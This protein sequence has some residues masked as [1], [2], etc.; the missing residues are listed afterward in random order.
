MERKAGAPKDE[1]MNIAILNCEWISRGPAEWE[2]QRDNNKKVKM[3]QT[4]AVYD[5]LVYLLIF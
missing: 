5:Q 4:G 2:A 1:G 3:E